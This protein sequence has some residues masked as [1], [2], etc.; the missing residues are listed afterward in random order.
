MVKLTK[1][2]CSALF[3]YAA[4]FPPSATAQIVND[5]FVI[6]AGVTSTVIASPSAKLNKSISSLINIL[7]AM[8]LRLEKLSQRIATRLNKIYSV[9]INSSDTEKIIKL[10]TQQKKLMIQVKQLK[11][12]LSKLDL[13]FQSASTA[14]ISKKEY[15]LFRSQAISLIGSIKEVHISESD[16]VT[17]MKNIASVSSTPEVNA[18]P[19]K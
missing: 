1:L 12:D 8:V 9:N 13:Q 18:V 15:P 3:L 2:I 17:Q 11:T 14:G 7:Q 6:P 10:T 4:F 5:S 19:S 16:L